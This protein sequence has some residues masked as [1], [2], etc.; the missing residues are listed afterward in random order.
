MFPILHLPAGEIMLPAV[1]QSPVCMLSLCKQLLSLDSAIFW[2]NTSKYSSSSSGWMTVL[3]DK[4]RCSING[5]GFFVS[6]TL[7]R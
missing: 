6:T 3:K 2:I 4:I 1:I 5:R 7:S